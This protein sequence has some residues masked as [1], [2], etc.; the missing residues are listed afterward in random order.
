MRFGFD[1]RK[2]PRSGHALDNYPLVPLPYIGYARE[3]LCKVIVGLGG[4]AGDDKGQWWSRSV[5]SNFSGG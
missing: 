4:D 5:V 1:D 2:V 3:G